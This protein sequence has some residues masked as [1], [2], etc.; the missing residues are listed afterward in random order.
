[1]SD[2]FDVRLKFTY[3][4]EQLDATGASVDKAVTF[5]VKHEDHYED[6]HSVILETLDKVDISPVQHHEPPVL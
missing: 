2:A 1:M 6:L 5:F 4:I 3:L